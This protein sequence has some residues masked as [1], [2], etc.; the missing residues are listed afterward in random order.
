MVTA[1]CDAYS[2]KFPS[3]NK[4]SPSSYVAYKTSLGGPALYRSRRELAN[5]PKIQA[6]VDL[7][8]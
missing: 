3:A 2:D 6:G 1:L 4:F 8:S 5:V 7:R